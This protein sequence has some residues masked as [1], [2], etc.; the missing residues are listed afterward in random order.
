MRILLSS[1][2]IINE[3]MEITFAAYDEDNTIVKESCHNI[4]SGLY[5]I[6]TDNNAWCIPGLSENE[7][8]GIV[9]KLL[10]QGYADLSRCGGYYECE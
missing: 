3:V 10:E 5:F 1:D 7:C 6:D 4:V 2:G 8:N 9:Y